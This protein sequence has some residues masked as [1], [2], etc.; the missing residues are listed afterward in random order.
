MALAEQEHLSNVDLYRSGPPW[1][2][3]INIIFTTKMRP[4][5]H[6]KERP[7]FVPKGHDLQNISLACL[8]NLW[9][10]VILPPEHV[11]THFKNTPHL[12]RFLRYCRPSQLA[13][14]VEEVAVKKELPHVTD[15]HF[16]NIS[17]TVYI[18]SCLC[19][20]SRNTATCHVQW[21]SKFV[22][23]DPR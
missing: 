6:R 22:Y 1:Q 5:A 11:G 4:G 9:L 23:M 18:Y 2:Q 7:D 10:E 16:L 14:L 20:V 15:T 21:D 17:V 13:I 8:F 19:A 3:E 12:F